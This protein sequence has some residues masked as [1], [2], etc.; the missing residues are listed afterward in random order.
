MKSTFTILLA[1]STTLAFGQVE[2]YVHTDCEGETRSVYDV[3]ESG[4]PL[5]V[6][7]K[8]FD[9]S[10][11]IF[12]ADDVV[13]FANDHVG[14]VEVWGAM[15]FKYSSATPTC[16][17]VQQWNSQHDWGENIFTFPDV[18]ENWRLIGVPRYYVVHPT[19]H[20]IEYEGSSFTTATSTALSIGV[21]TNTNDF[22]N[23]LEFSIFQS[24]NG[25]AIRKE[26]DISGTLRIFNIVGQEVY[27][28]ILNQGADL[29]LINAAFTEGVYIST[30]Y[31]D[32]GESSRKFVYRS[33]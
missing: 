17:E 15:T 20:E 5:L 31:S 19:T 1:L 7:S 11:C 6:A 2:D 29:E 16:D 21:I 30:I 9:C 14:Q 32:E 24:Q 22:E 12:S 8:G 25:L 33:L 18:D 4:L 23:N 26:A 13:E 28:Q 3:G 27:A 10:I